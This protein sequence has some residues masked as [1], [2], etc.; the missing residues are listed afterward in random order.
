MIHRYANI[1]EYVRMCN[2]RLLAYLMSYA[3]YTSVRVFGLVYFF[4]SRPQNGNSYNDIIFHYSYIPKISSHFKQS[5]SPEGSCHCEPHTGLR[6][7]APVN[8]L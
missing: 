3:L 5:I 8:G 4:K 1:Y 7:T 6:L 2:I